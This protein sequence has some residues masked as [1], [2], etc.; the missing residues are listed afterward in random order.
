MIL[1]VSTLKSTVT[2]STIDLSQELLKTTFKDDPIVEI[3]GYWDAKVDIDI[4]A[5]TQSGKVIVATCKYSNA[6]IKKS[7]L[8]KLQEKCSIA[9]I[10]ADIFVLISK[11]GFSNELKALKSDE[12]KLLS[13]KNFKNLVN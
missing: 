7:E 4:M 6:K 9:G 2:I 8:S 1:E 13:V 5:R 11:R 10:K 12:L 3:G